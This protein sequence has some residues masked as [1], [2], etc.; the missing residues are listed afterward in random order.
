MTNTLTNRKRICDCERIECLDGEPVV[1]RPCRLRLWHGDRYTEIR[2][3][4]VAD[5]WCGYPYAIGEICIETR[6]TVYCGRYA[7]EEVYAR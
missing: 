1:G 4:D 2:T 6:N 5:W 7:Q 3:S